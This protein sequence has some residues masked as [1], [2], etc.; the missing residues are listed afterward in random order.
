MHPTER[1]IRQ[2]KWVNEVALVL[3]L[4]VGAA[5]FAYLAIGFG[6]VLSEWFDQLPWLVA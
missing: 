4:L 2:V 5:L 1:R 6:L 3:V